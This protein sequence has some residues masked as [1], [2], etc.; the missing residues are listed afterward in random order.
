VVGL[1]HTQQT[2]GVGAAPHL[3]VRL[4]PSRAA[5]A[6]GLVRT[7]LAT[8]ARPSCHAARLALGGSDKECAE[9]VCSTNPTYRPVC[10]CIV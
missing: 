1:Y 10:S 6:V 7:L 5:A 2:R 9:S 8:S 3:L 4:L